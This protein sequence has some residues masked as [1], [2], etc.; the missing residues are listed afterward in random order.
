MPPDADFNY[1]AL[2]FAR[3]G[4]SPA[5]VKKLDL[6]LI[7]NSSVHKLKSIHVYCN[8]VALLL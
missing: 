5:G 8:C 3:L 1:L 7:S 4:T 6:Y 2:D